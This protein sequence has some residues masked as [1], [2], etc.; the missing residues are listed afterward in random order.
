ML[1]VCWWYTNKGGEPIFEYGN[2][3]AGLQIP[4]NLEFDMPCEHVEQR[5]RL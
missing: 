2:F 3:I 5:E 1:F 4:F